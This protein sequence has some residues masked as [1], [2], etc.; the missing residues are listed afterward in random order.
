MPLKIIV[1]HTEIPKDVNVFFAKKSP[2]Q[3]GRAYSKSS[4]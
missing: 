2:E 3:K 1:K 4:R